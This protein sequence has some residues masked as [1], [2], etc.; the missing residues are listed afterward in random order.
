[1]AA[2]ITIIAVASAASASAGGN[3][4]SRL[5]S[6]IATTTTATPA[7]YTGQGS[8]G[9]A[10]VNVATKGREAAAG[11]PAT[12]SRAREAA[13]SHSPEPILSGTTQHATTNA[14]APAPSAIARRRD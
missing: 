8:A 4:R 14:A 3:S 5:A 11:V 6:R 10:L 2:T 12:G 9:A 1:M 13:R 7:A